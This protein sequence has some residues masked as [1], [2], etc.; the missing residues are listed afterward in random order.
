M[1]TKVI[2]YPSA[3]GRTTIHAVIWEPEEKPVGILQI[4]H[5]ITEHIGRYERLAA[6]GTARGLVVCGNDHI[7]HGR[8]FSEEQPIRTYFGPEGSWKFLVQDTIEMSSMI[9]KAYPDLPLCLLGFSLGSFVVRNVL[10]QA[11]AYAD[12]AVLAGT[13]QQS[14]LALAVAR[15]IARS[16]A[17]KHG[18]EAVTETISKLT[19]DGYNKKFAPV[20]SKFDWLL[21]DESA[22][23]EFLRD[24]LRGED[25]TVG[26]FAEL[27][28]GMGRSMDPKLAGQM[29][30]HIP[31]LLLSGED[32]PVG[33][34]GKGVKKTKRFLERQGVERVE[35]KLYPGLRHDIF[36]EARCGEIHQE[37]IGWVLQ[38]SGTAMKGA[39]T[40]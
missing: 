28:R 12:A 10:F 32:D 37:L 35:M 39:E 27:L 9:R 19:Y 23:A 18:Y 31:I 3:D 26:A 15:R 13:G 17:T 34:F 16:E 33:D 7:G 21:A 25:F 29:K 20:Q 30:R 22:R 38:N 4:S 36:H 6:A 5:G 40:R 11:P 24:P 8:S 2:S 1:N 14:S